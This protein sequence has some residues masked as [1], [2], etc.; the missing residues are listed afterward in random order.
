M[1]QITARFEERGIFAV[2]PT[3]IFGLT[4]HYDL[5]RTGGINLIGIYQRESSAFARPA[6]GFEASA[7]LVAGVNTSLHFRPTALSRLVSSITNRNGSSEAFLDINGEFALTQPDPNRTGQAYLEEFEGISGTTLSLGSAV[8][9]FGSVPQSTAGLDPIARVRRHL[10]HG[11]CRADDLAEPDSGERRGGGAVL[12]PATST[13]ASSPWV[14]LTIPETVMYLTLHADTAGGVVQQNNSS[15]W[16]QPPRPGSPRWR[17]MQTAISTVGVDFTPVSYLEFW[18]YNDAAKSAENAGVN[19]VFDLG[20]VNEDAVGLAPDSMFVGASNDTTYRGRQYV[21]VGVLN[22]ER[23]SSGVFN[24]QT[25]DIGI[26][27]DIPPIVLPDLTTDPAFPLCQTV[28]GTSVQ[29]FPWGDLSARCTR[30]NGFLDTE[31][32]N[33][34]NILN[35][36]G[37]N[38]NVNRY[39]MSLT[40]TQYV[41]RKGVHRPVGRRAGRSIACRSGRR[42]PSSA[43]RTSG[44]C[45]RCG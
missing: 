14:K 34:D 37:P 44:W 29:I 24:A 1:V 10:R 20:Q 19:L 45:R 8:W 36:Q 32:L 28:L 25:D 33:G 2:A 7:N 35:A 21:G 17:S 13:R 27:G 31:D 4:T 41:V 9:Q 22:T 43:R 5:G 23:Q 15:Q 6:L 40:D 30:G 18:L 16:T 3:S 11:G 38:D 26:L 42:P 39:V 12:P